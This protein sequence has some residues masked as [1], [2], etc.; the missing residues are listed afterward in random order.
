MSRT[1]DIVEER[2]ALGPAAVL[3]PQRAAELLPWGESA[4]LAW[5]RERGLVREVKL[6]DGVRRVV[7]WGDV[8]DAIRGAPE[9]PPSAAPRPA[10]RLPRARL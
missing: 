10:S 8:L 9:P 6:S 3:S 2:L 4:A 7:I 5:L 1:A